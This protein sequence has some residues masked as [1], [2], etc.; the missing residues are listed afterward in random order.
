[1]AGFVPNII[2]VRP[3]I[4][5]FADVQSAEQLNQLM[6]AVGTSLIDKGAVSKWLQGIQQSF[7]DLYIAARALAV[8]ASELELLKEYLAMKIDMLSVQVQRLEGEKEDW[9]VVAESDS[10]LKES[11]VD[12]ASELESVATKLRTELVVKAQQ[13]QEVEAGRRRELEMMQTEREKIHTFKTTVSQELQAVSRQEKELRAQNAKYKKVLEAMSGYFDRVSMGGSVGSISHLSLGDSHE[14]TSQTEGSGGQRNSYVH[15][16][17]SD[18]GFS[19][20]ARNAGSFVERP[21]EI[22]GNERGGR[23]SASVVEAPTDQI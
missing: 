17:P 1:M 9:Q 5:T 19:D 20:E 7:A 18:A 6:Y 16:V 2:E 10:R 11:L 13:L 8:D 22:V 14:T 12:R 4:E 15:E 3:L 21:H 23:L